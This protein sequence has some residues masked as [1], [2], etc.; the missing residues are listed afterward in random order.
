MKF[1]LAAFIKDWFGL[2]AV[3][4]GVVSAVGFS[5]S[6]P[7]PARADVEQIQK[8]V[9]LQQ[10]QI[11]QQQCLILRVLLVNYQTQLERAQDDLAKNPESSS[12]KRDK[13]DAETQIASVTAQIRLFNCF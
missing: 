12:A 2:I 13:T 8:Q 7:W 11:T 4:A 10:Q 1:N 3:V 9:E 6:T 5:V